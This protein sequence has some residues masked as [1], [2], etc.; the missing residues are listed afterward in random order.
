MLTKKY[1]TRTYSKN[2]NILNCVRNIMDN[3]SEATLYKILTKTQWTNP[4]PP[5]S[6][7]KFWDNLVSHPLINFILKDAAKI[8]EKLAK[9]II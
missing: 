4:F 9:K 6:E 7:R 5:I 3:I 2:L 1:G 8:V